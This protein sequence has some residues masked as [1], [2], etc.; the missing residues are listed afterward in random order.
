MP[1]P[2]PPGYT[3]GPLLFLGTSVDSAVD[4]S[5]RQW[6]WREA[7]GY[8]ARLVLIT[9]QASSIK[10][11]ATL[12]EQLARLE[13]DRIE[14]VVAL[15]RIAARDPAHIAPVEQATGIVLVGDDPLLMA[16][17]LGGTLLAQAIRRANARSKL[18]AGLGAAG[19]FLCQHLIG[20]GSQPETLRGMVAFGPGLG[21][22]NRLV[23]D[24]TA[25]VVPLPVEH[26]HRLLAAAAMNPFLIG[27][28]LPPGSAAILYTNNTLQSAGPN[29][30]T[31]VDGQSILTA[32]LNAAPGEGITGALCYTLHTGDGFNLDEHN[33]RPAG[34]VDLPPTGPVTDVF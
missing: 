26:K 28:G 11:V 17:T 24:A 7:G 34:E 27:V 2:V 22:V 8:G 3:R 10:T 14:E 5:L 19:A 1:A 9:V 21:L 25:S 15:D 13:C 6:L 20:P 12:R 32:D 31:L 4:E 33:L 29:P 18:V 23:V 30:I 16:A